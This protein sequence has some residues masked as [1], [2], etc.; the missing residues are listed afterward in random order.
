[1]N[2]EELKGEVA[3]LANAVYDSADSGEETPAKSAIKDATF[4]WQGISFRVLGQNLRKIDKRTNQPS[5]F[6]K[7]AINGH[8]VFWL[9]RED[10]NEWY[11][12]VDGKPTVKSGVTNEGT[13]VA[14]AEM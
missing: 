3:P 8:N 10:V 1:M 11:L 13:L 2:L 9:I 7:L 5:R 12:M 4:Q 6:A 14:G